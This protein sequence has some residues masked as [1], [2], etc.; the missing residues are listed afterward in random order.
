MKLELNGNT[1]FASTGGRVFEPND[2]PIWFIHGSGQN[3]LTFMLQGRF[4]ANRGW[5]VIAADMPAHGLSNGEPLTSIQ[6]MSDWQV[7]LMDAL[8][9]KQAHIV[10]HSQGGLIALDMAYR[11]PDRITALSLIACAMAIPV[12]D[13]LLDMAKNKESAAI[14]A[15][16]DWGHGPDGHAHDHTMPGQNHL[17]YGVQMMAAN[18]T[19]ALYADL[20]SCV[21]Y[22]DGAM[23]AAAIKCPTQV[24]IAQHDKMTPMKFG[25]KM[26][27][28][29]GTDNLTVVPDAGH[30]LPS[31]RP[32]EINRALRPFLTKS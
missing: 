4:F 20:Q 29:L 14:N 13:A 3:H 25:L 11:Y 6:A 23:A 17:N 12:N 30:M 21:D 18:E 8:D 10:G 15:M 9:V 27:E 26:A 1:V 16:T 19:G 28:T 22:T 32:F 2:T 24:I 31:E 7:A 5:N